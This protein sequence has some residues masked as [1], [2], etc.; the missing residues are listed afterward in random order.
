MDLSKLSE[1]DKLKILENA[2]L[3]IFVPD[4]DKLYNPLARIPE[5]Y[6]DTP[7]LYVMYILSRPE[8]FYGICKE[9]LNIDVSPFQ[10][11]VLQQL[12]NYKFPMLI[13][14]RGMS[15]SWLLALY[16]LLRL[17]LIPKRKIII[18]GSGFR[19]SKLVF[20]YI[21]SFINNSKF[22]KSIIPESSI[23][24][25]N[26]CHSIYF[27]GGSIKAIPIGC[28][29]GDTLITTSNGIKSLYDLKNNDKS[30]IWSYNGYNEYSHF[31][32]SGICECF[33]VKT[34]RGYS[35]T[36]TPNHMIKIVRNNN[37]D[38]CRT[39]ELK[40]G[41]Y[42]VIDRTIR[43]NK[44]LY[45]HETSQ[46]YS[47]GLMLSSY[48]K[49]PLDKQLCH[50]FGSDFHRTITI[51]EW[52]NY[53]DIQP[54]DKFIPNRLLLSSRKDIRA[55]LL[56]LFSADGKISI[57]SNNS[58]VIE[59]RST[60]K[61]LVEQIQVLLLNFGIVSTISNR[62]KTDETPVFQIKIYGNDVDKFMY[63]I[64]FTLYREQDIYNNFVK[65]R[66]RN[67][68][69]YDVIPIDIDKLPRD[70][71]KGRKYLT[72][73]RAIKFN[74]Q[75]EL[76][77]PNFF[78]DKIVS[79][80]KLT[81]NQPMYDIH[82]PNGHEYTANG[83]LSHNSGG[84]KIRGLRA[85]DIIV[86]EFAAANREIF[87]TVIAGFAAVSSSPYEEA[88]KKA[89]KRLSKLLKIAIEEDN[90]PTL[91]GGN[92]IL[93]SGTAFYSFNHFFDYHKRWCSIIKSN[94]EGKKIQ[95]IVGDETSSLD[96]KDYT[97]IRIPVEMIPEGFMDEAQI[98]R[99]KATV[100][101]GI[102]AME[103]GACFSSDSTGFFRR[104]TIEECTVLPD[105]DYEFSNGKIIE[106]SLVY[107]EPMI[108][109]DSTKNYVLGL[110]PAMQEDNLAITIMEINPDFKKIVYCWTTNKKDHKE[111]INKHLCNEN[112]YY[113]YVVLKIRELMKRFNIVS[114]SIDMGGG[115]ATIMQSINDKHLMESNDDNIYPIND[116]LKPKD[117]DFET[118]LHI[119]EE[120]NFGNYAWYA[121]NNHSLKKEFEDRTILFPYIDSLTLADNPD[122]ISKSGEDTIARVAEEIM[123]MKVELSMI[124][125]TL[126]QTGR[127][128]WDTPD[129]KLGGGKKG[130]MRKDRYT[131]L[132]LANSSARLYGAIPNYDHITSGTASNTS[133]TSDNN[134]YTGNRMLANKLNELYT[135]M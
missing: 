92:K 133:T 37:I 129:I 76:V 31:Y 114:M 7:E 50:T 112:N 42:V 36:A 56:G 44:G 115:G 54:S 34:K 113:A 25:E 32:D 15:K 4:E 123:E 82:I 59:Y 61:R 39:D 45:N 55:C 99:A 41:D 98:A 53:W 40:V 93:I 132:L 135:N 18:C 106:N 21:E 12:W 116:P 62:D 103:Y 13:G 8:Y 130:K 109:G 47:L 111:K 9:W 43:D 87:E 28:M 3:G 120:V 91:S 5:E 19:Q 134:Y 17:L 26:D 64:G 67:I 118:G 46:S 68:S 58:A 69:V 88:T 73:D 33:S 2:Q 124:V 1:N 83:F 95:E 72:F 30:Q 101:S 6:E 122:I 24:H 16:A 128:H 117:T 97:V 60:S 81:V 77:N 105:R 14:S 79:I 80:E 131:S 84:D 71:I 75:H 23:R 51:G 86:D 74:F 38:W 48:D 63:E 90:D 11:A 85:N 104:K 70:I 65:N 20:Q 102:Y 57:L 29:S 49:Y 126:T 110:D 35:Y 100:H 94:G 127:E 22:M 89:R 119:V 125:V 78:Y 121:L 96:H 107:F 66:K 10:Q 108:T 27:N 52:L